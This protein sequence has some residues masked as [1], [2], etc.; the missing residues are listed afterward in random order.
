MSLS[1]GSRMAGRIAAAAILA[2]AATAC[3]SGGNQ[4]TLVCPVAAIAPELNI[5]PQFAPGSG[6]TPADVQASGT[7]TSFKRTCSRAQNGITIH[8]EVGILARRV[9]LAITQTT[10]PY[11]IAVADSHQHILAK[12]EFNLDASF[13]GGDSYRTFSSDFTIRLPL[14]SVT[15]GGD[16]VVLVGFQLTP[17]ERDFLRTHTPQ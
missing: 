13:V 3:S 5:I 6:H 14:H 10:L 2:A 7:I 8:A 12:E 1:H 16:Y 9:S 17:A 11:F 4:P 15:A